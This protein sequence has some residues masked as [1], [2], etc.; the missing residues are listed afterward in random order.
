[1]VM[2]D[3]AARP[4][5]VTLVAAT[6]MATC[7]RGQPRRRIGARAYDSD[8]LDQTGAE[9]GIGLL[10]PHRR[11][12]KRAASQNGRALRRDQRRGSMK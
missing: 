2:A 4:H 7:T 10:A 6:L 12:C 3:A 5:E 11:H 8:P 9:A 1:M